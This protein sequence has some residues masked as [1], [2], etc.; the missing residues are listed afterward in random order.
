LT[1]Y[2]RKNPIPIRI[3]DQWF[4]KHWGK[5]LNFRVKTG[6]LKKEGKEYS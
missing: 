4:I 1:H 6:E 2:E 5:E 3:F